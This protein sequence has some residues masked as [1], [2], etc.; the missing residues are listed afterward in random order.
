ME[1]KQKTRLPSKLS[2]CNTCDVVE[3]V[4]YG[5]IKTLDLSGCSL[6]DVGA[7]KEL[8]E[9]V[10]VLNLSGCR[11]QKPCGYWFEPDQGPV[12]F[13]DEAIKRLLYYKSLKSLDISGSNVT[14]KGLSYLGNDK[15]FPC[16]N[17]LTLT[18][19]AKIT[20]FGLLKS[21]LSNKNL[22]SLKIGNCENITSD[23]IKEFLCYFVLDKKQNKLKSLA[24][25]DYEIDDELLEI[26]EEF[27]NLKSLSFENSSQNK[28]RRALL[29]SKSTESLAALPIRELRLDGISLE[30][31]GSGE[32]FK[33]LTRSKSLERIYLPVEV[34]E[35]L[36]AAVCESNFESF[37]K[38]EDN[39]LSTKAR[40]LR[41]F[42]EEWEMGEL[43]GWWNRRSGLI[44]C[45]KSDC[46][47]Q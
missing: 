44:R 22:V 8:P 5:V 1:R 11:Y 32:M 12:L 17:D 45:S 35:S 24:L 41:K 33:P 4:P 26:L 38:R 40:E 10:E 23:S 30:L 36:R 2:C 7:L 14:D 20:K 31:G 16:L 25:V 9:D 29:S 27:K 37:M 46:M 6:T 19:C 42:F 28:E 15:M 21:G 47:V 3:P 43:P 18:N 13:D 39:S 34:D